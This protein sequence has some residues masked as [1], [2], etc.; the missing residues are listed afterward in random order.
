MEE[1]KQSECTPQVIAELLRQSKTIVYPTETCYGLGCDATNQKAV[2]NIF[3]IKGRNKKKPLLVLVDSIK[4]AQIYL[5]WNKKIDDLTKRYWPG[6][7]TIVAKVKS[8]LYLSRGVISDTGFLACRFTDD[9]FAS[10]IVHA[11]GV[12]LVSTSANRA[13]GENP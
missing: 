9:V 12:P 4:M 3:C 13:G 1:K 5:E 10:S 2:D 6:A 8:N 7:L 11:L